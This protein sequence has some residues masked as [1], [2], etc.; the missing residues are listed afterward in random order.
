MQKAMYDFRKPFYKV[1]LQWLT[2]HLINT[3]HKNNIS[4]S[5]SWL[6]DE[7]DWT[8]CWCSIIDWLSSSRLGKHT[9]PCHTKLNTNHSTNLWGN[10]QSL[11]NSVNCHWKTPKLNIWHYAY[12]L[13]NMLRNWF[14]V[15]NLLSL[16]WGKKN[17]VLVIT[18]IL[19]SDNII[20]CNW[21]FHFY[22]LSFKLSV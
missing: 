15:R 9:H 12:L 22:D 13:I 8:L 5:V 17:L 20:S 21:S 10:W 3:S 19:M 18:S 7:G 16:I 1:N 2:C 6:H 11:I 14:P 4:F